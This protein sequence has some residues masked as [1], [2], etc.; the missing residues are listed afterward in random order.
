[1]KKGNKSADWFIRK[2]KKSNPRKLQ[3]L[4]NSTLQNNIKNIINELYPTGVKLGVDITKI[5]AYSKSKSKYITGD[6][7]EKGTTKFYQFLGFST[8]E[9][10]LK[11]PLG[12]HLMERGDKSKLHIIISDMLTQIKNC[13]KIRIIIF[14]RG[15]TSSKIVLALQSLNLSF[16]M[17]YKRYKKL[18]ELFNLLEHP[19]IQTRDQFYSP[20]L[21]RIVHRKK[22][23]VWVINN[24]AYGNPSVNVNLVVQRVK[25]GKKLSK[26]KSSLRYEYF[27]YITSQDIDPESVYKLYGTRWRIETAFR[28]IKEKQAKTRVIHPCHRIWLFTV[29][30]L[31]YASWIYR[32]LPDSPESVLPEELTTQEL[33]KMYKN[34]TY[35]RITLYELSE[36]YLEIIK[37]QQPLFL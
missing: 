16:I 36:Q 10:Q 19:R 3:Q 35:S 28:Q 5:P 23:D 31:I 26:K 27:V 1:M 20:K 34:W 37:I 24:Y 8:I 29:A 30:C 2:S 7:A 17:A 4:V 13:I 15:F 11:F 32:H 18:K 25:K 6:S 9:R 21:D 12:I 33:Q 22:E 14:D